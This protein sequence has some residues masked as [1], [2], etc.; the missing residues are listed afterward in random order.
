MLG[1]IS[2]YLCLL[3]SGLIV[4]MWLSLQIIKQALSLITLD[5]LP[6]TNKNKFWW[7]VCL[8]TTIICKEIIY[9]FSIST[10]FKMSARFSFLLYCTEKDIDLHCQLFPLIL[11]KWG[12]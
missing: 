10:T 2:L 8:N 6:S 1:M 11:S 9:K 12:A 3:S 5:C 7:L 4:I